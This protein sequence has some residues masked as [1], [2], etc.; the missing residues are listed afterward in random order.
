MLRRL[1]IDREL[2]VNIRA[3]QMR[4]VGH[5]MRRGKIEDLSLT[6]TIPGYRARGRQKKYMD[7]IIRTVG[8]G[9]KAV[10]ILQIKRD[11]E[12]WQSMVANV[13]SGTAL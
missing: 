4:F 6:S 2:L 1:G 10:Q 9:S 5:V 3:R 13:W 8:D 12:T 7:G 11:R